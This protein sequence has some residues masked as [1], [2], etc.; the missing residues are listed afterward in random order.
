[1]Q[2]VEVKIHGCKSMAIK[3][4]KEPRKMANTTA[5][6]VQHRTHCSLVSKNTATKTCMPLARRKV[7]SMTSCWQ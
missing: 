6:H 4:G 2:I 1:M 3:E 7:K 5:G